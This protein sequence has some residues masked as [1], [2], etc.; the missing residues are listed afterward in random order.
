MTRSAVTH[1]LD[2]Q[3]AY[4][5][6][7]ASRATGIAASTLRALCARGELQARKVGKGWIISRRS[8]LSYID[9]QTHDP[10]PRLAQPFPTHSR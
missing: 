7:Q 6:E 2:E 4:N 9:G 1:R 8:L 10:A 3:L 5:I